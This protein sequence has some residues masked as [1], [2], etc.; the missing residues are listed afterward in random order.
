MVQTYF[1]LAKLVQ[2][3]K[4]FGT[5]LVTISLFYNEFSCT[6]ICHKYFRLK[7]DENIIKTIQNLL[8]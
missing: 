8:K 3:T 4:Y 2:N 5:R 6:K 1:A 7:Y